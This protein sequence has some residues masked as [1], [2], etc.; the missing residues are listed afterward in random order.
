[1]HFFAAFDDCLTAKDIG[2]VLFTA[3]PSVIIMSEVRIFI[4]PLAF[5][6]HFEL[7]GTQKSS[8][9]HQFSRIQSKK[10]PIDCFRRL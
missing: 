10:R 9:W 3:E 7:G 6:F 1:M 8:L 5:D 4:K 2:D